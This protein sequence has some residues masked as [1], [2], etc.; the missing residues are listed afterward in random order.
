M[1]S[2]KKKTINIV[3]KILLLCPNIQLNAGL[4]VN[5]IG[6]IHDTQCGISGSF[7][8]VMSTHEALSKLS[9]QFTN[10]KEELLLLLLKLISISLKN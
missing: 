1:D 8:K 2:I 10:L 3:E 9:E 6:E 4:S 7:S 5:G